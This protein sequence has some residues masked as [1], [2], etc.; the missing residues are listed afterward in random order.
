MT[1]FERT[2]RRVYSPWVLIPYLFLI[3]MSYLFLDKPIALW[4]AAHPEFSK[5]GLAHA[6]TDFG[7]GWPYFF[8]L[9][10]LALALYHHQSFK[11]LH[12]VLYVWASVCACGLIA[13]VF[14]VLL[15][16]ARPT[17]YLSKGL[18]GFQW[19]E[20]HARYWSFPSGHSSVV[21]SFSLALA[22]VFQRYRYLFLCYG[23]IVA[24]SRVVVLA[25][26]LSDIMAAFLLSIFVVLM[27]LDKL[28]TIKHFNSDLV[29]T[30]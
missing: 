30:S 2:L 4:F 18:Y 12:Q 8:G 20:L 9:P 23:F 10:L 1:N 16:R 26:F 3:A 7:L 21:F 14:K 27:V 25:H 22:L 17:L 15:S 5:S 28:K 24:L 6:I 29:L 19:L 11:R 13:D